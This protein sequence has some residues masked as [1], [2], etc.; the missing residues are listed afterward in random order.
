[1]I[2]I[3]AHAIDRYKQRVRS[4]TD[5][6]AR[7]ALLASAA[8]VVTFARGAQIFVRLAGGQRVI[9]QGD[10]VVTVL[11]ADHYRRQI[12]RRGLGRFGCSEFEKEGL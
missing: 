3:S 1:M 6:Q 5:E 7:A 2:H 12:R 10:A 9:V 11:P 8:K 4:C